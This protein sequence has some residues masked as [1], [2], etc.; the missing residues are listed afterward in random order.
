MGDALK[1][2]TAIRFAWSIFPSL[3]KEGWRV[4]PGWFEAVLIVALLLVFQI[5]VAA[6]P[7]PPKPPAVAPAAP[8]ATA[9]P[10]TAA[11]TLEQA[12][13]RLAAL[14]T[15]RD[16]PEAE[17]SQAQDLYQQAISRLQAA[18]NYADSAAAYQQLQQ[19][20]P[21]ETARL[22]QTLTSEPPPAP[23]PNLSPDDL[24]KQLAN[25]QAD[26][27]QPNRPGPRVSRPI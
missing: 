18:K 13:A 10:A 16:L 24:A 20:A 23:A 9:T 15:L 1:A 12:Q 22:Q 6:P 2:N 4:A 11:P 5:S 19:S 27:R 26:L 21:A 14:A 7:A 25:N 8:P 3:A 17:R